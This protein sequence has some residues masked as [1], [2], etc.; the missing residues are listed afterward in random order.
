MHNANNNAQRKNHH[1]NIW[2][3]SFRRFVSSEMH[4]PFIIIVVF[5]FET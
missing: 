5:L 4:I 2:H 3:F 1:K